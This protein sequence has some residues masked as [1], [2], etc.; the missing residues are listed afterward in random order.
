MFV[1]MY[2]FRATE[3][4]QLSL[5]RNDVVYYLESEPSG[6]M[7]GQKKASGEIGWFPGA[8]VREGVGTH[9]CIHSGSEINIQV[10]LTTHESPFQKYNAGRGDSIGERERV[11]IMVVHVV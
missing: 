5:E 3:L 11:V 1:A 9:G 6:W 7:R 8:Y 4:T 10:S 2:P